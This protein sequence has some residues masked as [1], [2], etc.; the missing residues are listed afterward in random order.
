MSDSS[1][2][3]YQDYGYM[4][5]KGFCSSQEAESEAEL[6]RKA[7]DEQLAELGRYN[8]D[9]QVVAAF[10]QYDPYNHLLRKWRSRLSQAMGIPCLE[11]VSSYARIYERGAVLRKHKDRFALQHSATVCLSQDDDSWGICLIDR[12]GS[13]VIVRQSVGDA[14]LFQG[15]LHHWREGPYLGTEQTQAFLHYC[16]S[17]SKFKLHCLDVQD[18][19]RKG[20]LRMCKPAISRVWRGI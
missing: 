16:D 2:N 12:K 6:M 5:V 8:R 15:R 9:R 1:A 7:R 19:I 4:V 3:F 18:R 11:E 10:S 17:R 14:L 20:V 13:T